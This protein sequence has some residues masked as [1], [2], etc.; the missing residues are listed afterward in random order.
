VRSQT[1]KGAELDER[2][3]AVETARKAKT[4]R[5]EARAAA[6]AAAQPKKKAKPAPQP[7]PSS[8]RAVARQG[9]PPRPTCCTAQDEDE[10]E[11]DEEE[12]EEAAPPAGPAHVEAKEV[13]RSD[14]HEYLV[15]YTG[16]GRFKCPKC[17]MMLGKQ[18]CVCMR[19]G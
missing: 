7:P 18:Q 4:A 11:D 1:L 2:R 3:E 8:V 13:E 14:G 5:D 19:R 16:A 12:E 15:Q 6:S 9:G 17:K 10:D